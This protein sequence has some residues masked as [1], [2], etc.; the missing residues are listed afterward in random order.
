[1]ITRQ[2]YQR[3]R[4]NCLKSFIDL[5][6]TEGLEIGAFDLPT[7]PKELGHCEY[8]D[9]RSAE[10]LVQYWNTPP[11]TVVPVKYIINRDTALHRQIDRKFDYIILCHVIE[12]VPNVIAYI[13]SLRKLLK[14]NGII[15]ITCP[16]KRRT[17]DLSRPSTTV[18]HLLADYYYNAGYPALDHVLESGKAWIEEVKQKSLSSSK[19]FY[20][21]ACTYYESGLVDTHCHV[22]QDDELFSQIEYLIKGGVIDGLKV[23]G[24]F[25]ND[26]DYNEF[27]LVLQ[28]RKFKNPQASKPKSNLSEVEKLRVELSRT[29]DE[30]HKTQ[31]IIRA[32]ETSKFWKLRQGW[33]KFKKAF[34]LPSNE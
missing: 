11:E 7:V 2:D 25:P 12:H 28:A 32:M 3:N 19:E 33:F 17:E 30:L 4:L 5:E 14:P 13:Q 16:D 29:L 9:F 8:A 23:V 21:W 22:W 24:K 27:A 15:L 31:E 10:E 26:P 20:E 6:N 34:H 1:M 18:E